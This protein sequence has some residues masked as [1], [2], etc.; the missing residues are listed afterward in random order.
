MT[1][2]CLQPLAQGLVLLAL[3]SGAWLVLK[4]ERSGWVPSDTHVKFSDLDR[5][6]AKSY[7]CYWNQVEHCSG[8]RKY[9]SPSLFPA[10]CL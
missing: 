4:E 5:S 7:I 3:I 9:K 8:P 2:V 1:E 10:S 6:G